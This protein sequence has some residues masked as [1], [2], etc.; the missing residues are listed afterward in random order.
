MTL[1]STLINQSTGV[2]VATTTV[3]GIN[4]VATD[5]MVSQATDDQSF[6]TPLPLGLSYVGYYVAGRT[7]S[8][9][10]VVALAGTLYSLGGTVSS[11]ASPPG[12]PWGIVTAGNAI[13]ANTNTTVNPNPISSGSGTQVS[14][15]IINA[16]T[17]PAGSFGYLIDNF[18]VTGLTPGAFVT[19]ADL[20]DATDG[21]RVAFS[22]NTVSGDGTYR[23]AATFNDSPVSVVGSAYNLNLLI[24]GSVRA[25]CVV[26]IVAPFLKVVAPSITYPGAGGTN[27]SASPVITSS[28]FATVNGADTHMNSDWEIYTDPAMTVLFRQSLNDSTN[29]V[30]WTPSPALGENTVYYMRMRHR[31][32]TAGASQWS[33]QVQFTTVSI[34]VAQP[35]ITAPTAAATGIAVIPTFTASAFSTSSGVDTH[36]AS[37]WQI[38]LDSGFTSIVQ[39][40]LG[41]TTN[42]VTWTPPIGLNQSTTY[43]VRVRYKGLTS[44]NYGTYSTTVMFTTAVP[45]GLSWTYVNISPTYP[46]GLIYSN[47]LGKFVNVLANFA[48][49]TTSSDGVTWSGLINNDLSSI[50]S[51]SGISPVPAELNGWHYAVTS[52]PSVVVRSAD[53]VTWAIVHSYTGSQSILSTDPTNPRI[54]A[55]N[56]S[57]FL[58]VIQSGVRGFLTSTNGT[59]WTFTSFATAAAD[60]V[61]STGVQ[62]AP[63][64]MSH[65]GTKYLCSP[66]TNS[67]QDPQPAVMTSVDGINWVAQLGGSGVF[68]LGG[69]TYG[70]GLWV[71]NPI[72]KTYLN[73]VI[74][75]STTGLAGSWVERPMPI[76]PTPTAGSIYT[77]ADTYFANGTWYVP[78][79]DGGGGGG[80]FA[81]VDANTWTYRIGSNY[82]TVPGG[83]SDIYRRG[84]LG[85]GNG[86]TNAR[87]ASNSSHIVISGYLDISTSSTRYFLVS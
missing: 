72:Y 84:G 54:L 6:V 2:P 35:S 12:A 14:P 15:Y 55:A 68:D 1:L 63:K 46:T 23:V 53:L 66:E 80:V 75:K 9:Q 59:T 67:G 4:T 36:G 79:G 16:V 64:I 76:G 44:G 39:Q 56:G 40:T 26:N 17:V 28:P 77:G 8:P 33:A 58:P 18:V 31:G 24:G 82:S 7:Y 65:D 86:L 11:N 38:A 52:F 85:A 13:P 83:P 29:K 37:D 71:T 41:D 87:L 73:P 62:F 32:T 25:T 50:V 3:A 60:V 70:N 34:V 20:N 22:T 78:Y 21:G 43:Y 19:I 27:I 69:A 48:A 42:K 61:A 51:Y 74:Y 30:S 49:V 57:L 45:V 47:T 10:Q 5:A 81:S